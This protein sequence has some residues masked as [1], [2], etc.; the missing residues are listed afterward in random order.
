MIRVIFFGRARELESLGVMILNLFIDT[1]CSILNQEAVD[2]ALANVRRTISTLYFSDLS[3]V[4]LNA[5]M[6]D[7]DQPR[8]FL[9][10]RLDVTNVD[11]GTLVHRQLARLTPRAVSQELSTTAA[12]Y[13]QVVEAVLQSQRQALVSHHERSDTPQVRSIN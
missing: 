8:S 7:D 13:A 4:V 6:I 11:T 1:R 2:V 5:W 10:A 12:I 9:V 3:T